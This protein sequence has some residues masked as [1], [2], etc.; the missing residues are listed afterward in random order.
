MMKQLNLFDKDD[1]GIN[2]LE[3]IIDEQ[4]EEIKYLKAEVEYE[5][6][7][8]TKGITNNDW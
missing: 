5:R 7:L 8:R 2:D 4:R 3:R 6:L 1:R